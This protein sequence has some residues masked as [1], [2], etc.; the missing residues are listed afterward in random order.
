MHQVTSEY[1]EI[2][3]SDTVDAIILVIKI[4]FLYGSFHHGGVTP[5]GQK[6]N[7]ISELVWLFRA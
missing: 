1:V 4:V 2:L 3:L 5:V 7:Q 6:Q